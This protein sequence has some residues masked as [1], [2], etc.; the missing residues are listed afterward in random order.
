MFY[1]EIKKTFHCESRSTVESVEERLIWREESPIDKEVVWSPG[2][3]RAHSVSY[4]PAG[5]LENKELLTEYLGDS[6]LSIEV[7][8]RISQQIPELKQHLFLVVECRGEYGTMTKKYSR[9]TYRSL[10]RG[11]FDMSVLDNRIDKGFFYINR[12]D[13]LKRVHA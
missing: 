3:V 8:K 12:V 5:G 4:I 13:A 9:N 11:D 2:F 10:V 1:K 6:C 7:V